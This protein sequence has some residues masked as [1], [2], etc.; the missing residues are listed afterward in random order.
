MPE[1]V[2]DVSD[3]V[4]IK[5]KHI[6]ISIR[7][8]TIWVLLSFFVLTSA[9]CQET[10]HPPNFLIILID[11]LGSQDIGC[12][13]QTYIQTP[14]ID[15]LAEQ[16]MRWTNAY[17]A[18][19]VC[20][21]TRAA[22]LTG[23]ST[24]RVH[25][26]GHITAIGRHR[27][28]ENGKI[29][30][31]DDLMYLPHEEILIPEAI[32]HLGYKSIS[33]GKWHV[34]HEG[35]YPTDQG[36]DINIGG[37]THGSPPS[38][39]F[40]YKA[41]KDWNPSIPTLHGGK[42]GEYLTDRLTDEAIA[43][44]EENKANPFLVYLTHYAVHTPLEAPAD[45]V[46]KYTS[47]LKGTKID[48]V[49]AA[50]VE[51]V[52]TNIGKLLERINQLELDK[53]TVVLFASDNGAV[54]S[55]SDNTPY[56]RGK[57]HLYEGGIRV[58]FIMR[59]PNHIKP[60]SISENLIISQDI[61]STIVDI[62][63]AKNR[64]KHQTDGR[65]LVFDFTKNSKKDIDLF[66]YYPHYSPQSKMPGAAIRSGNYKLIQFYDPVKVELYNLEADI[67]ET[68]D[69]SGQMPEK[70]HQL[71][72]KLE[73]WLDESGTILHTPNPNYKAEKE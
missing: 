4:R 23:K 24:A 38:H 58:P 55:S 48:P 47:I 44:I 70:T 39:I 53:N 9:C 15:K 33:I 19:P 73:K 37:W 54:E 21:P 31:P 45:L 42:E 22:L 51:S 36:F 2:I 50:M 16:G 43:F 27:Y 14:N 41:D 18:C 46:E 61:F 59:W 25:F 28:P 13:G 29:I 65:S 64:I 7:K 32:K 6:M 72:G 17:S 34:G 57:G 68:N 3:K 30:P 49:Y 67:G 35:Y 26:T 8:L 10:N 11:D 63:G 60:G 12:Y 5:E 62:A 66:W 52:D 56:R 1:L 71:S 69:L 40:P 20:S